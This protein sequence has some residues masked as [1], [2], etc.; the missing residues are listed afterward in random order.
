VTAASAGPIFRLY[1]HHGLITFLLF[2]VPLLPG[3]VESHTRLYLKFIRLFELDLAYT[4]DAIKIIF[5]RRGHKAYRTFKQDHPEII[6]PT[7]IFNILYQQKDLNHSLS[8]IDKLLN[9]KPQRTHPYADV[10]RATLYREI[11]II[12]KAFAKNPEFINSLVEFFSRAIGR[13]TAQTA[14]KEALNTTKSLLLKAQL[15]EK[16]VR[17]YHLNSHYYQLEASVKV[18]LAG[19]ASV[20][21][22][23]LRETIKHPSL[24]NK[25][26]SKNT[27]CLLDG[28]SKLQSL[29]LPDHRLETKS[30]YVN[31]QHL[32]AD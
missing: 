30:L 11:P 28:L 8:L 26:G 12:I 3:V 5:G 23:P 7:Q 2:F 25:F 10:F 21:S 6:R 29:A 27:R 19:S 14:Q 9:D 16:M 18:K 32:A 22:A 20:Y 31:H 24:I 13:E 17:V 4:E 1:H 15:E